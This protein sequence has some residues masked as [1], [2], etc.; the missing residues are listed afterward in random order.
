MAYV[1]LLCVCLV[2]QGAVPSFAAALFGQR[3]DALNFILCTGSA[4]I[5]DQSGAAGGSHPCLSGQCAMAGSD[6]GIPH[7]GQ[8]W[9]I[10][11][12]CPARHTGA[13]DRIAR[14]GDIL[15]VAI[16]GPPRNP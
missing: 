14:S 13:D 4:P 10:D 11:Q 7:A 12:T 6:P 15:R 2:L 3:Q 8:A 5:E 16:R 1:L 9:I